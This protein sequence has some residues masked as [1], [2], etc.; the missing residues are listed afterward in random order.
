MK[1]PICNSELRRDYANN[2]Y[3]LEMYTCP[4]HDAVVYGTLLG[5]V[6]VEDESGVREFKY[7]WENQSYAEREKV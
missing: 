5:F 2:V 3:D 6:S 4:I 1:C 7:D